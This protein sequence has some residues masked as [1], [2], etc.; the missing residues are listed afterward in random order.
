[1]R[2]D[3]LI[4]IDG[5]NVIKA[6]PELAE[7]EGSSLEQA[8]ERLIGM[9]VNYANFTGDSVRIVF[10]AH[11]VKGNAGSQE[12]LDGVEVIFTRYQETADAVIEKMAGES[13]SGGYDVFVVTGDEAE[14]WVSFGR[15]AWRMTPRELRDEVKRVLRQLERWERKEYESENMLLYRLSNRIKGIFEEWRRSR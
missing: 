13:R 6:W 15:G 1:M 11:Q 8:R 4:I 12:T 3:R 10:D 5:Y 9:M 7:L 2:T 14:Q